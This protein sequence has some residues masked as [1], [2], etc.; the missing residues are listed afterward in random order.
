MSPSSSAIYRP[1]RNQQRAVTLIDVLPFVEWF[2]GEIG[3]KSAKCVDQVSAQVRINILW[4][5]L[6]DSRPVSRPVGV[7][8]NDPVRFGPAQT[9]N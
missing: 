6:G 7:V 5:K 8:A 9:I 3:R 4:Q 1:L 2:E